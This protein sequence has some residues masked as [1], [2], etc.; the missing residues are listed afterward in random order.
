MAKE[1]SHY[2]V[3]IYV[4]TVICAL[5][6]AA[7]AVGIVDGWILTAAGAMAI[8]AS[9]A[10]LHVVLDR[11]RVGVGLKPLPLDGSTRPRHRS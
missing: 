2:P 3:P 8:T 7:V 6:L 9:L 5:G 4:L 1:R 11:R 10:R